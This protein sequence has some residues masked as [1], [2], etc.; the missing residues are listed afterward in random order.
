M[1]ETAN[2]TPAE[3][4]VC[5]RAWVGSR[6]RRRFRPQRGVVRLSV[7]HPGAETHRHFDLFGC[8]LEWEVGTRNMSCME[9][10]SFQSA[11]AQIE[12]AQIGLAKVAV[13]KINIGNVH[14]A[15]IH[16]AKVAPAKIGALAGFGTPIEFLAAAFAK[17]QVQGI[18]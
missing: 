14:G 9:A 13:G 12:S 6:I 1:P 15:Q 4:L 2:P 18:G 7:A 5:A 3:G 10:R 16:A 17:Q 8:Q 11:A